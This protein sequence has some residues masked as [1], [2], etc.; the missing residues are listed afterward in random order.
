RGEKNWVFIKNSIF[1]SP[2]YPPRAAAGGALGLLRV[3]IRFT[4]T[5]YP[6]TP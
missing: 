1:L 2:K 4:T 6:Q 5:F 3:K